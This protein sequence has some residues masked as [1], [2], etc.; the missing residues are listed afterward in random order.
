MTV[1]ISRVR[2]WGF[3]IVATSFAVA[4]VESGVVFHA[5]ALLPG[6]DKPVHAI[7][8]F[9]LVLAFCPARDGRRL[10][11]V[12]AIAMGLAWE[13]VQFV[14]DPYQGHTAAMYAL[15]T[16]TD[17]AADVFGAVLTLRTR[18]GPTAAS[19]A[20]TSATPR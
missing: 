2:A 16:V 18:P 1:A 9:G 12:A 10:G 17:L 19:H 4:L 15:D 7:T 6:W 11:V 3:A 5:D 14:I 13:V 8:A 20:I